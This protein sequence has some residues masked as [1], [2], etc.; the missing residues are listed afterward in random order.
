MYK[1]HLFLIAIVICIVGITNGQ[2]QL[3][4]PGTPEPDISEET[5]L[6]LLQRDSEIDQDQVDPSSLTGLV[7]ILSLHLIEAG[8]Q[9]NRLNSQKIVDALLAFPA[10][11]PVLVES[12]IAAL[13]CSASPSDSVSSFI[14]SYLNS[15]IERV[16]REAA[17]AMVQRKQNMDLALPILVELGDFLELYHLL[18]PAAAESILHSGAECSPRWEGRWQA[19]Y[20]LQAYGDSTTI[21]SVA[22]E[23]IAKAPV[24]VADNSVARAKHQALS[25][26]IKRRIEVP[27]TDVARLA[28]D[29]N[30][31]V[32]ISS[33]DA[34]SKWA[35]EGSAD[36]YA[37]LER[38]ASQNQDPNLRVTA[39]AAKAFI[40]ST[41][42][43]QK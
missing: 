5:I 20:A 26:L 41:S 7:D 16:R 3:P 6:H 11:D 12:K 23:I 32:R 39:A 1:K 27:V 19:A 25:F 22:R 40:D 13:R 14:A 38:I 24:D 10:K 29:Q 15:S 28:D 42:G 17:R 43:R 37:A 2:R 9:A 8:R 35:Q 34:L 30:L 33:V 36:A 31:L 18:E 4:P 21:I